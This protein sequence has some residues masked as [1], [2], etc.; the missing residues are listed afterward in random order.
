MSSLVLPG[1]GFSYSPSLANMFSVEDS[2]DIYLANLYG[3]K[4]KILNIIV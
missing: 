3:E 1:R 4:T 2:M